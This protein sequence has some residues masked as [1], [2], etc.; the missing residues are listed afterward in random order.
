MMA[1]G[2]DISSLIA[3]RTATFHPFNR[4][5][6]ELRLKI[7]SLFPQIR[8]MIKITSDDILYSP[9]TRHHSCNST[10]SCVPPRAGCDPCILRHRVKISTIVPA[11]LQINKESRQII[12]G[13]YPLLFSAPTAN[14]PVRIDFELDTLYFVD[15]EAHISFGRADHENLGY[16]CVAAERN[17]IKQSLRQV[18]IGDDMW[19]QKLPFPNLTSVLA[20]AWIDDQG[21]N[22]KLQLLLEERNQRLVEQEGR[23]SS[24]AKLKI[25][26][27]QKAQF[28]RMI[29]SSLPSV[30]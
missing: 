6:I 11:T 24:L 15:Q 17:I 10:P 18:A 8:R 2:T 29:L 23:D 12:I 20:R 3:T 7:Y 25:D 26:F 30:S 19:I 1:N 27:L 22:R 14:R 13:R 5:P 28:D 9:S 21:Q 4:L 16:E